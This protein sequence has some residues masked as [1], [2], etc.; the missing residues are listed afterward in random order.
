MKLYFLL[1][2]FAQNNIFLTLTNFKGEVIIWKSLGKVKIKG[3]KKLTNSFLKNFIFSNLNEIRLFKNFKLHIKLKGYNKTKKKFT[4]LLLLF[5][6]EV[7][8]SL[9]D[10][11]KEPMNGC[12]PKKKRRL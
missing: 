11:F 10:D 8:F 6:Q 12:K 1:I 5:L 7:T 4:R 2:L 9:T 3:L